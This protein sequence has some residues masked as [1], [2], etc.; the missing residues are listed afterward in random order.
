MTLINLS[1]T[2]SY[3]FI[4]KKSPIP[5]NTNRGININISIE[6]Y[7]QS[8]MLQ[9]SYQ[10][11]DGVSQIIYSLLIWSLINKIVTLIAIF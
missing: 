11:I 7:I 2:I 10:Y 1:L 3:L 4:K 5:Y 8:Y 6:D 9:I